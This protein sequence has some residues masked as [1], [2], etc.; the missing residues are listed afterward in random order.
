MDIIATTCIWK[1]KTMTVKRRSNG[2]LQSVS[3]N[4]VNRRWKS[5]RCSRNIKTKTTKWRHTSGCVREQN[6]YADGEM[7]FS[8]RERE[9][10]AVLFGIQRFHIYLYG[11]SHFTVYSDQKALERIFT[12]VRQA[13][14]R[15]QNFVLKL[16]PY[17]FTV[18]YLKGSGNISDILSRT[19]IQ[20]TDNETCDLTEIC[21]L[22]N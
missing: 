12:S 16:Q 9:G 6:T 17:N 15:I 7:I 19:P 4:T 20:E 13:P 22:C 2:L 5:V 11:M 8:N 1:T 14:T 21:L 3:R 18:K 10:L